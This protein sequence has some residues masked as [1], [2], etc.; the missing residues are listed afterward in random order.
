MALGAIAFWNLYQDDNK[1]ELSN[2][3]NISTWEKETSDLK[4]EAD[5]IKKNT[6]KASKI[7]PDSDLGKI[8]TK[9]L[10]VSGEE[11]AEEYLSHLFTRDGK[12]L[13]WKYN[14]DSVAIGVLG[15]VRIYSLET[16]D[17]QHYGTL[18]ININSDYSLDY[19]PSDYIY[20][21]DPDNYTEPKEEKVVRT[22][23][24]DGVRY[25]RKCGNKLIPGSLYCNKCGTKVQEDRKESDIDFVELISKSVEDVWNKVPYKDF[26]N[27][28]RYSLE[29]VV[30]PMFLFDYNILDNILMD[31]K[32]LIYKVFNRLAR[33]YSEKNPYRKDEYST[34]CYYYSDDTIEFVINLPKTS[35]MVICEQI[36]FFVNKRTHNQ[37]FFTVEYNT[38]CALCE[39][40]PEHLHINYGPISLS[41]SRGRVFDI[42]CNKIGIS[43]DSLDIEDRIII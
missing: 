9:P 5:I 24:K 16:L 31:E 2:S 4:Q 7:V 28:T 32:D 43:K 13:R 14:G 40:T 37:A 12:K 21:S 6:V 33:K 3:Q 29:H 42:Y 11:S 25:C 38:P 26:V 20:I 19:A 15:K 1:F 17:G 18:Y 27:K 35:T 23:Q 8:T 36:I 10:Y 30:F 34:K 41:E 39:W 22:S